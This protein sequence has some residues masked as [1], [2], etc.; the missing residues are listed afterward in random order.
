M[1]LWS[2]RRVRTL[3]VT[4]H[5]GRLDKADLTRLGPIPITR[6]ERTLI[7]LAS[8]MASEQL[9]GK[10]DDLLRRELIQLRRLESRLAAAGARHPGARTLRRLIEERRDAAIS[11]SELETRFLRALREEGF[12]TPTSQYEIRHD[13]RFVARVDFA[14]PD[15]K[16]VIEAYGKGHH[17]TW[18]D[19]EDDLARQN[20]LVA[21]G[22]RV[23]V[24]TWS[25]LHTDRSA[26]MRSIARALAA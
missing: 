18:T 8:M 23:I 22:W 4:S 11:E 1:H 17:S 16:L 15:R 14:Y 2:P 7:D 24:V 25:R 5:I 9:E 20:D 13:G 12:P 10:L 26:L 19:H 3:G 6:P 21:L